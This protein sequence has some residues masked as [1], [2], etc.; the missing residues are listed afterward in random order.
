MPAA[1][2]QPR[3]GHKDSEPRGV[4]IV[5]NFTPSPEKIAAALTL[6]LEGIEAQRPAG[7]EAE[8]GVDG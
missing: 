5:R 4:T 8:E 2:R 7:A 1:T 3:V 6:L